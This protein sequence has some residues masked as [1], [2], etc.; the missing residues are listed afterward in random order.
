MVVINLVLTLEEMVANILDEMSDQ[1][2]ADEARI[3]AKRFARRPDEAHTAQLL[4]RLADRLDPR[5]LGT[6]KGIAGEKIEVGQAVYRG[7]DGRFYLADR[8]GYV[9]VA[10][11]PIAAGQEFAED[12]SRPGHFRP[13]RG[14]VDFETEP[15]DPGWYGVLFSGDDGAELWGEARCWLDGEWR[16]GTNLACIRSSAPFGTKSEAEAWTL[17]QDDWLR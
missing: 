16:D 15:T 1:N 11:E 4:T 12:E 2:L 7:D 6:M 5:P 14:R 13:L 3:A 9:G 10:V 17:A 8:K